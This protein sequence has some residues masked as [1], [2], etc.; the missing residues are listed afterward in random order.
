MREIT[1]LDE[2]G[3]DIDACEKNAENDYYYPI[4]WIVDQRDNE[5][6]KNLFLQINIL[7]EKN[8]ITKVNFLSAFNIIFLILLLTLTYSRSL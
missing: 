2:F 6:M 8:Q 7:F 1:W 4:I 3:K 5:I